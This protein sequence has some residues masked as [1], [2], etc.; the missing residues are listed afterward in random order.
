MKKNTIFVLFLCVL[1][2]VELLPYLLTAIFPNICYGCTTIGKWQQYGNI[3]YKLAYISWF[4]YMTLFV[5][6]IYTSW[7]IKNPTVKYISIL[8]CLIMIYIPT[9]PLLNIITLFLCFIYKNPPFITDYHSIFPSSV[10]IEK[11][12]NIIIDE[13]QKYSKKHKPD[14]IRKTN[15]GFIIENTSI[16]K[17]C[18]RTIYLKKVGKIQD[19]M[20]LYFPHTIE[21]IQDEQIHNAFFSILDPGVEIP[22]H[23]GYYK[24]YLRYHMGIIIPNNNTHRTDDKAY[25]VCNGEKYI[26]K[27]KEGV[28][29]DDMYL[30][31]VK[32][33][34][35]QTRVVLYL[36][37]KRNHESYGVDRI[38][39][40]GLY[41]IEHSILLNVFLQNQHSQTKINL[42]H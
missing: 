35:N 11:K 24:G 16:E 2:L 9:L 22:P 6:L 4:A 28:V 14:C 18:W 20:T 25:L 40:M 32:N 36:D 21:C 27:E 37:I 7:F 3:H 1:S 19:D 10:S 8:A 13:Y 38:N 39:D 12:A 41:L 30:H 42:G 15:P 23:V 33:P 26:W 34:T 31:Y 5:Y 29:F 17:N